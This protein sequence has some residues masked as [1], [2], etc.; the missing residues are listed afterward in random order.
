MNTKKEKEWTKAEL[1]A[2]DDN[3]VI[4]VCQH[5][6][7]TYTTTRNTYPYKP[8]IV[9]ESQAL[10]AIKEGNLVESPELKVEGITQYFIR[11]N[12]SGRI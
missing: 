7:G 8:K 3:S 4:D 2:Q 5:E 10:Q 9:S 11:R 1:I 12:W 6:D